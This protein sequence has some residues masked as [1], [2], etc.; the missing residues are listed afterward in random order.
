[1]RPTRT[2]RYYSNEMQKLDKD[3][4]FLLVGKELDSYKG[5]LQGISRGM[6]S[7]DLTSEDAYIELRLYY[8]NK[9]TL[10]EDNVQKTCYSNSGTQGCKSNGLSVITIDQLIAS[11]KRSKTDL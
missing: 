2:Q 10:R 6:A 5:F 9:L 11:A 3:L 7:K 4:R 1:M 8:D